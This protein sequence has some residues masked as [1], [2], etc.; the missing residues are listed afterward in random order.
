MSALPLLIGNRSDDP[1]KMSGGI[2]GYLLTLI[3]TLSF[4]EAIHMLDPSKASPNGL[5]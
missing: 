2:F 5:A 1:C 3:T 4:W